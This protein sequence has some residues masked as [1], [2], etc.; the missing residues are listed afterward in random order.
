ML[1]AEALMEA[2][3]EYSDEDADALLAGM[4][5]EYFD[6]KPEDLEYTLPSELDEALKAAL[7]AISQGKQT[8]VPTVENADGQWKY[9]LTTGADGRPWI[10]GEH[11][12]EEW[13]GIL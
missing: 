7:E 10:T 8:G 12:E 11:E 2:A 5:V 13:E 9:A 3:E 6:E 1:A 4:L